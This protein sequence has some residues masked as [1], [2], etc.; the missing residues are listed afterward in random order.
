MKTAKLSDVAAVAAEHL[1]AMLRGADRDAALQA[2]TIETIKAVASALAAA[3]PGFDRNLFGLSAGLT[4]AQI[5]GPRVR[6]G[7]GMPVLPWNP[8]R[9]GYHGG[10]W[11]CPCRAGSHLACRCQPAE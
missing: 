4:Y 9:H 6:P 2:R 8:A 10:L 1:E 7:P 5:M 11:E 3:D